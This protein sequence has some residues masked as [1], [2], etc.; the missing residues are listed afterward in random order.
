MR[1][2]FRFADGLIADHRDDFGFYRWARQALGPPGQL[3]GWTP[4]IRGSVRKRARAALDEF[5]AAQ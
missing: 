3:L 5:I 4:L 2:T 1:A